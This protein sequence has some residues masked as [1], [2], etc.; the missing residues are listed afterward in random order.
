MLD[1][2]LN[3]YFILVFIKYKTIRKGLERV[4]TTEI[5]TFVGTEMHT[6]NIKA[7]SILLL[8]LLCFSSEGWQ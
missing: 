2:T 4:N 1:F 8:L 5:F 7:G 6:K 3:L